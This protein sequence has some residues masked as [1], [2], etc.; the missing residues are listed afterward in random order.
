MMQ[1]IWQR[2]GPIL[3]VAV[4]VVDPISAGAGT[5]GVEGDESPG[6]RRTRVDRETSDARAAACRDLEPL[7][8]FSRRTGRLAPWSRKPPNSRAVIHI[9]M[10][11]SPARLRP[12]SSS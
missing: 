3:V 5:L 6:I 4:A 8:E 9:V 2:L 10:W 1:A 11:I 7:G 12:E